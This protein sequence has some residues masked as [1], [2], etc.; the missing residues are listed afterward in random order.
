MLSLCPQLNWLLAV[1]A[2][3]WEKWEPLFERDAEN[4]HIYQVGVSLTQ[5]PAVVCEYYARNQIDEVVAPQA[6]HQRDL[7]GASY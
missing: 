7:E 4:V 1:G 3:L 6:Y 2:R 5:H